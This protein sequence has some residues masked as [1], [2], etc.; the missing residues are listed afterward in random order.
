MLQ[1]VIIFSM[2]KLQKNY[3]LESF[4]LPERNKKSAKHGFKIDL[5]KQLNYV[6]SA[7]WTPGPGPF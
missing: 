7:F 3:N 5:R 1:G 6:F 4:L 2:H